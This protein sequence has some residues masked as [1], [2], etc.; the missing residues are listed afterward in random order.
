MTPQIGHFS[1]NIINLFKFSNCS[2]NAFKKTLF[3]S[4]MAS[5][6]SAGQCLYN[7]PVLLQTLSYYNET[8]LPGQLFSIEDQCKSVFGPDSSYSACFVLNLI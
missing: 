7:S 4:N 3:T 8:Y 2:I 6:S 1:Q 5:I